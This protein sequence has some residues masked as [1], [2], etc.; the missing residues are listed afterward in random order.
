MFRFEKDYQ[1][2]RKIILN[3]NYRS[4]DEIIQMSKNLIKNNSSR[5]EKNIM[6]PKGNNNKNDENS[7]ENENILPVYQ[8][9]AVPRSE[10]LPDR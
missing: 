4:T 7:N 10:Y 8:P 6:S 9:P 2:C 5:F 1:A 3:I